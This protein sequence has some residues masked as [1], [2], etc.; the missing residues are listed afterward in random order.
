MRSEEDLV[1]PKKLKEKDRRRARKLA[2]EA[3]EAVQSDN[4]DLAEKIIR[5]AVA[6]QP[7]NPVFWNDQGVILGL[8]RKDAEAGES[9]R[10]ALSLAPTFAE[11]FAHLA[12]L[13]VRQGFLTQAVA[14]QAQAVSLAPDNIGLA[15]RLEAYRSLAGQGEPAPVTTPTVAADR[16]S[17]AAVDDSDRTWSER[18][19]KLDWP[20]LTDGLTR[21]GCVLIPHLMDVQTCAALRGMYDDG[22][23]FARTVVMDRPE[24]GLGEYRYFRAPIPQVVDRLRRAVYPHVARIANGW[25]QLLGEPERYPEEWGA[26]REECHRAGQSTPTP[27]LLKYQAGGFNALHRDL[28]GAVFFPIQMA[29]VLSPR[30]DPADLQADGFRGGGFLFCDVPQVKKSR[31]REVAAGLGDAVLF[32]TRDRLVPV[33]GAYGLQPVKHGVTLIT[34]G[35]R[36]VL[37]V[38]FHEYR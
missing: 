20:A 11:P 22:A 21:D 25:Q 12:A 17:G 29:V 6:A 36:F 14:L 32:C 8:R 5:R 7:D 31:H 26:F 38:P 34:A 30:A 33:G 18:V 27:I 37:G 9:F 4:L 28:R 13:R 23:L 2:D 15:E 16:P 10:S 35:T 1:N 19:A 24:F 3:W